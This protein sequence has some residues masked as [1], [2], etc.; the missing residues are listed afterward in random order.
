M[1]TTDFSTAFAV[2]FSAEIR[3]VVYRS[4]FRRHWFLTLSVIDLYF[5]R[6]ANLV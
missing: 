4:D 2:F 6:N 3:R 1:C 5:F